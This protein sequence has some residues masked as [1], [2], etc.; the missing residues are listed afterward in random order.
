MFLSSR[1]FYVLAIYKKKNPA[2]DES[3]LFR[4]Y[5]ESV[6]AE[7]TFNLSFKRDKLQLFGPKN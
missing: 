6:T 1:P 5:N 3:V 7:P 4:K 2:K